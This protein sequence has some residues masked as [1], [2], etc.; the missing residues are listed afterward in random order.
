M[1]VTSRKPREEGKV[2]ETFEAL[3]ARPLTADEVPAYVDEYVPEDRREHVS[4]QIAPLIAGRTA[5]SPLFLR[6]AIEQAL[7]G[8]LM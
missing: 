4:A 7:K 6:F 5:F 2:W 8:D 1:V 3:V